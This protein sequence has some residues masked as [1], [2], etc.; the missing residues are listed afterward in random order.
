MT[1]QPTLRAQ[2]AALRPQPAALR[3]QR[4]LSNLNER[5]ESYVVIAAPHSDPSAQPPQ[6]SESYVVIAAPHSD[7]SAGS[8]GLAVHRPP[9]IRELT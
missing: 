6:R 3:A 2:P 1:A 8:G 4:A 5:S 7:P 9:G